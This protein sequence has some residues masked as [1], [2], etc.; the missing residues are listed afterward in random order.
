MC[1]R[2]S[3]LE[4]GISVDDF[5]RQNGVGSL[6]NEIYAL[7]FKSDKKKAQVSCHYSA[8]NLDFVKNIA[9]SKAPGFEASYIFNKKNLL[10]DYDFGIEFNISLPSP[11]DIFR[12]QK[13]KETP[14]NEPG[15]FEGLS[16]FTIIDHFKKLVI[17]L[18]FD[19]ADIFTLPIYSVSSSEGGFEKV[20][21]QLALLL[22]LKG[23][24]ER[25]NLSFSVQDNRK[26]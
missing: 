18:V 19:K 25:F 20:F 21:Q 26:T 12:R 6:T 23:K 1:I 4:K 10:N 13:L 9:F 11:N 17:E 24:S 15:I 2:D 5:N 22:V 16:S 14:L 7:S 8:K 3:L